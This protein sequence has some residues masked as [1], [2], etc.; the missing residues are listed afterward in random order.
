[1]ACLFVITRD[2]KGA[3]SFVSE[4]PEILVFD[5]PLVDIFKLFNSVDYIDF[6]DH[7]ERSDHGKLADLVNHVN[8]KLFN[9]QR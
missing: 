6:I 2:V 5:I 8:H 9:S 1:M 7:I 4:A 3:K